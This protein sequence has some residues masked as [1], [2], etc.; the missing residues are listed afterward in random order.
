MQ[1]IVD[2][3][4]MTLGTCYYPEHWDKSLW[5]D[6]L[7]RMLKVGIK[8]VRIA[9]FAWN[10]FEPIE[11]V[12]DYSFFDEFLELALEKGM[13]VIFCTPTAT[14]PAWMSTKYPEIL[15]ADKEGNLLRHG[16]RRHYN[17]NSPKFREFTRRIVEK[18]GEHYASHPAIIGWQ[19]DNEFNCEINEFYSESDTIAFRRFLSNK[20]GSLDA[21]NDAWGTAFWN[22]TYT[23][24]AEV[25]VP[26][27]TANNTVNPHRLMDYYRFISDSVCSYAK[28]Q[29]DILRKY[30]KEEDFITTNGLFGNLDNHR[31]NK[32]CL[33]FIMYDSY[34]NFAYCLDNYEE[35]DLLKDRK[36][37]RNLTEV[38]SISPIFGIMEQQSG[39]NGWTNRMEAPT[40]RPGQLTLWTMQS[41]AH[42]ADFVSYFRWR[43]CTIGTEIY[44]HGILD[45][46]GRDNRRI[47]EVAEVYEKLEKMQEIAGST[48]KAKVGILKDYDNIFDTQLDAWHSRVDRKSNSSL[49]TALQLSHV[50]TDFVYLTNVSE[51]EEMLQKLKQYEV[52][53]YPH[54]T[55]LTKERMELLEAYVASGGK[56]VMGCR[57]GYKD[58]HGRCVMDCLP[59]LAAKLTGTDIPEYSFVAPDDGKVMVNWDGVEVEA[60]VFNDLLAPVGETA[61]VLA[62]YAGSY[63]A[64]TPALIRNRF[65][66]GEAYYFGGAF[67]L[68]TAKLFIQKLGIAEPY[69]DV[70]EIPEDA[71]L[72]V[73]EKGGKAYL[74]VLNYKTYDISVNVKKE[75]KEL[76]GGEVVNG[77][78]TLK[79]YET[80]IFVL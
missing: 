27:K 14:P 40:P 37:S 46:S 71:E 48:F 15:N 45:Y 73:R 56:L 2:G 44:W 24:W 77:T 66:E 53:F 76:L 75:M 33:D 6:D 41:I 3:T 31:M 9:E 18:I 54:A 72:A 23:D 32:E 1:N 63:Y 49:F 42:G 4:N 13:K 35:K 67:A 20:Y 17:Y 64:G 10:K 19:L 55:I 58:I 51:K 57:T 68:D 80:K 69:G 60:A 26:R 78:I 62:T 61:E 70:I 59:G 7:D 79:P 21:L 22:Q 36:W 65:G 25:D 47:R 52:L 11:G 30:I 38:R 74:F 8:V 5:A 16:C 34:P 39:A 12:F 29:T 50:P 28:M 43:T